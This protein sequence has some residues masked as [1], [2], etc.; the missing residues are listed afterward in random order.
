MNSSPKFP[1]LA[2]AHTATDSSALDHLAATVNRLVRA[3]RRQT[4]THYG[5]AGLFW[6]ITA[7]SVAVLAIR[8][9]TL[10]DSLLSV[11]IG[12]ATFT[13]IVA[14]LTI[15]LTIGWLTR[16]SPLA[17]AIL[18]DI[19]LNLKQRLSSAW[20]LYE[21]D[22]QSATAAGISRQ[23]LKSRTPVGQRVF[24]LSAKSGNAQYTRPGVRWG[25]LVPAAALLLLLLNTLNF[26]RFAGQ[27]A[28]Q[29]DS[30]VQREGTTL[31]TYGGSLALRARNDNLEASQKMAESIRQTGRRMEGGTLARGPALDRLNQLRRDISNAHQR[32]APRNGNARA[33]SESD[34]SR[35]RSVIENAASELNNGTASVSELRD[36]TSLKNALATANINTEAFS[37]ALQDAHNGDPENLEKILQEL[38]EDGRAAR[39]AEELERAYERVQSIRENLGAQ[40]EPRSSAPS[41]N[42]S[43]SQTDDDFAE[44]NSDMAQAENSDSSSVV[45]S[46]RGRSGGRTPAPDVTLNDASDAAPDP[47]QPGVR[48]AGKIGEGS[49]VVTQTRIAAK[50]GEVTTPMQT[51]NPQ[52]QQKLEAIL[53]KDTLPAHQKAYVRRYFLELSRAVSAAPPGAPSVGDSSNNLPAADEP[54]K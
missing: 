24:P 17:V 36:N 38:R 39:D 2:A 10:P 50:Q 13:C 4:L 11:S 32:L 8:L 44:Q 42:A 34:Q 33:V 3:E 41:G 31:R 20:E 12:H 37:K 30:A 19:R 26:E 14:G 22:N 1:I 9:G 54:L 25:R 27:G 29:V 45:F 53:A 40:A 52:Q 35:A 5:L 18:A 7:A 46:D 28:S 51:S 23:L 49:E 48:P 43:G 21:N 15:G 16:R 47:D 6:G